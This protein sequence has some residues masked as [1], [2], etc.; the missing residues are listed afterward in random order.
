MFFTAS[1]G[2]VISKPK[3]NTTHLLCLSGWYGSPVSYNMTIYGAEVT[4]RSK[5]IKDCYN[6]GVTFWKGE[7][8]IGKYYV[9]DSNGNDIP[10]NDII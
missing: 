9:K 7:S 8:N 5:K 1:A 6:K 3:C 4:K 10:D 2:I